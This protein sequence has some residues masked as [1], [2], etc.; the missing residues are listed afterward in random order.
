MIDSVLII[1]QSNMAGRGFVND[2][3]EINDER[4]K[5]LRNGRWQT[6]F[7][8][9]CPDRRTSGVC[10][11]ESFA[12]RYI[13]DHDGVEIGIIPCADGGTSVTQWAEGGL[14]YD[15]TVFQAT[16]AKR[17]SNIVAV[18]WHQGEADCSPERYPLYR[19]RAL[20]IFEALRRDLDLGEVPFIVGGLGDFLPLR[21]ISPNLK[22]YMK[23]NEQ[24]LRIAELPGYAFASAEG[25]SANE[26]N[27]HFSAAALLEF[28]ERYYEV[29]KRMEKERSSTEKKLDDSNRSE[30]ELL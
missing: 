28:G 14:L 2:V 19:D 6:M 18:L 11:A 15:N 30:M 21:E 20:A 16:L 26:D 5:M 1:G 4:I 9:V 3:P 29:F 10:L 12:K 17:T 22:N 24:L 7:R 23:L 27:L 25:L 13:E 8:P